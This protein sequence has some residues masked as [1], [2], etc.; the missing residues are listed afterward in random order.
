[1]GAE[2]TYKKDPPTATGVDILQRKKGSNDG[3]RTYDGGGFKYFVKT[4]L[5]SWKPKLKV[6]ILS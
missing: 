4:R 2:N 6:S 5:K 3:P 1:M